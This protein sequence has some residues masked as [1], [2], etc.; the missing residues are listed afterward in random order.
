[1]SGDEVR[2]PPDLGGGVSLGDSDD[3]WPPLLDLVLHVTFAC[4]IFLDHP[5]NIFFVEDVVVHL[6]LG[7]AINKIYTKAKIKLGF[8]KTLD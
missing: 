7:L 6:P 1:M 8:S 2:S 4:K 5:Q 3:V